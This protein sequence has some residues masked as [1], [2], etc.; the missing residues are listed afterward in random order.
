MAASLESF[1]EKLQA[2]GVQVGQAEGDRIV[3]ESREQAAGIVSAAKEEAEGIVSA[4]QEEAKSLVEKGRTELRLA[5]RDTAYSL[6]DVLTRCLRGVLARPVERQLE[7]KELVARLLHEVVVRYSEADA[8][9]RRDL[10]INVPKEMQAELADWALSELHKAGMKQESDKGAGVSI[11]LKG[12]LRDAGF[13]YKIE[14]G[15]VEVTVNSV[16]SQL[17]ELLSPRLRELLDEAMAQEEQG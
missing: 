15:T 3:A 10:E 8:S 1:V 4:A 9:C 13:E 5:A 2:E 14:G 17:V 6:R 16:V 7:E 12:T 11:D